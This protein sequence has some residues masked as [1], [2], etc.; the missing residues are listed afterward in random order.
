MTEEGGMQRGGV[1]FMGR[2]CL[3]APWGNPL[4]GHSVQGLVRLLTRLTGLNG[5][6]SRTSRQMLPGWISGAFRWTSEV[7]PD[8]PLGRFF[9]IIYRGQ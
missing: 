5:Q 8:L 9:Q 3:Y 7:L 1:C 4:S 2:G 6:I